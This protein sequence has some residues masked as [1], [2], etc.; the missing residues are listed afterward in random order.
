MSPGRREALMLGAAG[1]AAAAAGFL[2]G[3][4]LLRRGEEDAPDALRLA[5]FPDLEGRVRSFTE[6]RGKIMVCNFWA[7]WC[8]PCRDEIPLLVAAN[9]KYG[10]SGVEVIG[11]A[12]D[13]AAKVVEY[14]ASFKISYPILV[15]G[16][17][18]ISLMRTLGNSSGGLP[19]TVVADRQGTP[20]HRKLG[21]LKQAELDEILQPLVRS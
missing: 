14:A 13:N 17:E 15:T 5:S 2:A 18:G 9:Q 1:I 21:A 3:P 10:G 4:L 8:E 6:W 11:I 12:I 19:Y 7:T 16:A 20:I